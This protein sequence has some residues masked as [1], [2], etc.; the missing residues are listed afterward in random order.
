MRSLFLDEQG[1]VAH[2]H[3]MDTSYVYIAIA[4]LPFLLWSAFIFLLSEA[5]MDASYSGREKLSDDRPTDDQMADVVTVPYGLIFPL[6]YHTP[7]ASRE[8]G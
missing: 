6:Y 4:L 7:V 3:G 5:D 2:H 1:P 8:I